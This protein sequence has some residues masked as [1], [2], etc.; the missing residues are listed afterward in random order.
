MKSRAV[1]VDSIQKLLIQLGQAGRSVNVSLVNS[2]IQVECFLIQI[3]ELLNLK[4]LL[5]GHLIRDY[6]AKGL[7]VTLL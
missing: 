3:N 7:F 5:T 2:S 4:L 6:Q 1:T